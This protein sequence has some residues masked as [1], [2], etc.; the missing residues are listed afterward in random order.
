MNA[1]PSPDTHVIV[2]DHTPELRRGAEPRRIGKHPALAAPYSM[3]VA[4]TPRAVRA[5]GLDHLRFTLHDMK[6]TDNVV[7]QFGHMSGDE[8][9][10]DLKRGD[11][12]PREIA[13]AQLDLY[14][15]ALT[16]AP[17]APTIDERK[18]EPRFE[19]LAAIDGAAH[20]PLG[21]AVNQLT[22]APVD[23]PVCKCHDWMGDEWYFL[24]RGVCLF[25]INECT[26]PTRR[27]TKT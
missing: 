8:Y 27:Q 12:V 1:K 17:P 7:V 15:F 18:I 24:P 3:T 6:L 25:D 13:D 4:M 23:S 9:R 19:E 26:D 21:D 20:H 10:F 16:G 5:I 22:E 14:A 11:H 2:G